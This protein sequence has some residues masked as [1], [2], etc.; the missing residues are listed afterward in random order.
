MR[1]SG[2]SQGVWLTIP[3]PLRSESGGESKVAS[4]EN[5]VGGSEGRGWRRRGVCREWEGS[6][7]G[8]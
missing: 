4:V 6:G 5:G 1:T 2:R 3:D 7:G 8:Q